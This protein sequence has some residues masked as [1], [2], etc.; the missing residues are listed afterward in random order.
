M[1]TTTY[2]NNS[3]NVDDG[4]DDDDNKMTRLRQSLFFGFIERIRKGVQ[5]TGG[6]ITCSQALA[7]NEPAIFRKAVKQ[8]NRAHVT[9]P[10]PKLRNS[11]IVGSVCT[12]QDGK[13]VLL[14]FWTFQLRISVVA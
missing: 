3:G 2:D 6:N 5:G 11:V 10:P 4:D 13:I 7:T 8:S 12:W 14:F 1:T 9:D